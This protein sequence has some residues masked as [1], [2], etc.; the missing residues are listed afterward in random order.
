MKNY[1]PSQPNKKTKILFLIKGL[2]LG[3]AERMI[4]DSLPYLDRDRFSYEFA[5]LMPSKDFLAPQIQSAGFAVHCLGMNSNYYLPRAIMQL[6]KLIEEERFELVHAHLPLAGLAARFAGRTGRVPVIYTEHNVQE[7]YHPVTRW[8][9]RKT[10]GWNSH[11]ISV[12]AEVTASLKRAGAG[13]SVP[14]T[15]VLNSIPIELVRREAVG[16]DLL[17]EEFGI[18]K[19]HLVVGTVAV[20]R[21]QKCLDIWLKVAK[22]VCDQDKRVTFL[23]A[24]AGPEAAHLKK[25]VGTLGL[26]N[27]VI[28]P[29]FRPD[30]RRIIGLLDVFMLTSEYEGLPIALL[31]A[32][33]LGKAIVATAVGGIPET[34]EDGEEGF[35]ARQGDIELLAK[36]VCLFLESEPLRCEMGRRAAEKAE[37]NFDLRNRIRQIEGIYEEITATGYAN[38]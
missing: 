37:M 38:G 18:P 26:E 1:S 35:L 31:E 21:K 7:R 5:Y 13:S 10:M 32:M 25:I 19:G 12:S 28:M 11:V 2:G 24:G 29:G 6:Q 9:N 34:I 20:F 22:E 17:R 8:A 23:L 30:G 33:A 14:I 15:T 27:R 36:Q 4:I 3:G 16:V